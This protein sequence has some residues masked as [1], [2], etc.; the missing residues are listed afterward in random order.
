[1]LLKEHIIRMLFFV[2]FINLKFISR[3]DLASACV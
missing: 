2:G 1:M 3:S